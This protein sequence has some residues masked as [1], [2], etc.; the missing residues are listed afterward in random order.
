MA[1]QGVA[2]YTGTSDGIIALTKCDGLYPQLVSLLERSKVAQCGEAAA[3]AA[4]AL[5]NLSQQP[6]ERVKIVHTD[7]AVAAAA[8]CCTTS[9]DPAEV[10][11]YCSMLLANLTQLQPGIE[12][13]L[14]AGGAPGDALRALVPAL[15]TAALDA[16][17]GSRVAHVALA[18]TNAAQQ[19]GGRA[20]LLRALLEHCEGGDVNNDRRTLAEAL[21]DQLASDDATCRR[22]TAR[23]IRNL[24]F[25]AGPSEDAAAREALL[26]PADD[27]IGAASA[28]T[29]T[30]AGAHRALIAGVAVRLAVHCARYSD[31]ERGEFAVEIKSALCAAGLKPRGHDE[32]ERFPQE[33]E[34]E[35]R[36]VLTESLLLL[37]AS[38]RARATMRSLGI[39]PLLREAH[40]AEPD[41]AHRVR[42][43]NEQVV[44]AFWLSAEAVGKPP[45]GGA[46]D[47][48]TQEEKAAVEEVLD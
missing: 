2:G 36:L 4:A 8:K 12:Q 6:S 45:E 39:Y 48:N 30:T 1:V 43:A 33:A 19:A 47:G 35:D 22:G 34:L 11:E 23:C 15:A 25:A 32:A 46:M 20:V 42:D 27:A 37:T 21:C 40:L 7:G 18:L 26:G 44:E 5:V 10:Q 17:S 28:T 14:A 41:E 31:E 29:A 24:A 13:L 9:S 3:S 38:P 16:A